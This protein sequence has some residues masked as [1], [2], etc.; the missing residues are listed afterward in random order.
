MI[1]FWE[2]IKNIDWLFSYVPFVLLFFLWLKEQCWS[3]RKR[4]KR[5]GLFGYRLIYADQKGNKNQKDF[6]KLL[7]SKKYDI[8]G[9]PDY[10]FQKRLGRAIVPVELKSGAIKDSALPHAGDKM[11]LA[12]YFLLIEDVYGVRPKYGRLVYKDYMFDIKN[13][14]IL[15][16]EVRKT[17]AAM[18][19]MLKTGQGKA[20]CSVA[21]CRYCVCKETVCPYW[22][23]T[24]QRKVKA[25]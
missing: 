13:T 14:L 24:K 3:I 2:S 6:G 4:K 10:I 22:N 12:T 11:Q 17:L 16:R 9:K 5:Q 1:L 20:N 18:R 25:E 19:H 21:G 23:V 8:Q 15:R 7:Y